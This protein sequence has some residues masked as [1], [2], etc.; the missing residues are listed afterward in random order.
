MR[1]LGERKRSKIPYRV[2][3]LDHETEMKVKPRITITFYSSFDH[4]HIVN[5]IEFFQLRVKLRSLANL[6]TYTRILILIIE[7]REC[8]EMCPFADHLSNAECLIKEFRDTM[9]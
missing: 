2:D 4:L 9:K 1:L 7:V 6:S 3:R 8:R 5:F